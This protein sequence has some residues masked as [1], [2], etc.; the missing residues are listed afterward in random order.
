M[1]FFEQQ[2][3]ARSRTW[4]MLLLFVLAVAAIVA[5]LNLVGVA[6]YIW[7]FDPPILYERN[8]L[9]AVPRHVY[10]WSPAGI[11]GVAA[12]GTGRRRYLLSGRGVAEPGM[13]RACHQET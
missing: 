10:G 8:L 5:V 13:T 1:D 12:R 7:I 4:L 6:V 11:L 3:R 9:Q 2:H